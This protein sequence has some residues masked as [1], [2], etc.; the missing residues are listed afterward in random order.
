[1]STRLSSPHNIRK[2]EVETLPGKILLIVGVCLSIHEMVGQKLYEVL[3]NM[4]GRY[5]STVQTA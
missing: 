2:V 5:E 3:R 4:P 1:M